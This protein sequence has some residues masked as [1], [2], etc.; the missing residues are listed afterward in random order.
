MLALIAAVVNVIVA[1]V[2]GLVW[3]IAGLAVFT[4][5]MLLILIGGQIFGVVL[6][7]ANLPWIGLFYFLLLP[8]LPLTFLLLVVNVIGAVTVGWIP[9]GFLVVL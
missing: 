5:D 4:L 3:P 2:M 6:L 9:V 8:F 1:I 7:L